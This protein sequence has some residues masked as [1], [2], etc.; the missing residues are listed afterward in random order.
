MP[1]VS[2][3]RDR[4]FEALGEKFS[5]SAGGL[6]LCDADQHVQQTELDGSCQDRNE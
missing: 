1:I 6:Q 3:G 4:L 5:E 2:V